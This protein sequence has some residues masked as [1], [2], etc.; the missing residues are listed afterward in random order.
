MSTISEKHVALQG[1]SGFLGKPTT[2]ERTAPDSVGQYQHFEESSIYWHPF[3][4]A[5][6][7]GARHA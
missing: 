1:A 2:E 3:T 7:G 4:G 5:H 6:A